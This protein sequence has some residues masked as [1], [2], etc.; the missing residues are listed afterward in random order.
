MTADFAVIDQ[1]ARKNMFA[2]A[3]KA[4]VKA[5]PELAMQVA[6]LY[7]KRCLDLLG[8]AKSAGIGILGQMQVEFGAEGRQ[9]RLVADR[10][11]CG[12]QQLRKDQPRN[13]AGCP[14]TY[15]P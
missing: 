13:R 7:K 8:F 11:R 14:V 5:D 12:C 10:R 2:R 1:A 15:P 9:T 6:Q 3:A 4:E